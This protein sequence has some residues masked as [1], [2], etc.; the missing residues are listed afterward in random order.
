MTRSGKWKHPNELISDINK[1]QQHGMACAVEF[2]IN[3]LQLQPPIPAGAAD[4]AAAA[5]IGKLISAANYA[6]LLLQPAVC[7][8]TSKSSFEKL[9]RVRAN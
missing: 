9:N 1:I 7:E 5:A 6:V 4:A 8:R 3:V 2:V